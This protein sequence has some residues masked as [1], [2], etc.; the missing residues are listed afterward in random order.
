VDEAQR[1]QLIALGAWA[2]RLADPE[3]ELGSW[4]GG[5][6]Q[7]DG[8]ISMPWFE[9]SPEALA[10]LRDVGAN[11]WIEPFDW[12]AWLQSPAGRHLR[13]A[14]G[15]IEAAGPDDLRRM[16]TAIVR[17]ER[18][19]DGSIEG[20]H[21]SGLLVRICRRAGDLARDTGQG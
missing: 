12:M 4:A 17:S 15:A 9:L 5:E 13:E 16:L 18:F 8:A 14:P 11:G 3:F 21:G 1:R 6:R 19:T 20:A 2:D 10:F 7:P